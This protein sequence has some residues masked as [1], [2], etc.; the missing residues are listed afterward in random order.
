MRDHSIQT[1]PV[2]L[3][4]VW[5]S[6]NSQGYAL[7]DDREMGLSRRFPDEFRQMHFNKYILRH[8]QGDRPADRLRARDVVRYWRHDGGLSLQEHETIT[9]TDRADIPGKRDHS[10]VRLLS[11]P[12]ARK[13][14]C[15]FLQLV[16]P[17]RR[18]P[19]GTFGLNLFRT[20]TN[21]VTQPHHDQEEFIIVYVL[22]RIGG[23]AETYLYEPDGVAET[24]DPIA[25]PV[26]R[27]QL[28]KGEILIFED[29]L[30]KHGATPLRNPSGGTAMRDA[31]VCTVDHRGTYLAESAATSSAALPRTKAG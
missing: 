19:E 13:L 30:F 6:L 27:H 31:L 22:T 18:K 12:Q 8:D 5:A 2:D 14:I 28:D 9:I 25:E 11:D 23:G 4:D 10:R 26:L 21:I 7:T 16:P 1:G 3:K 17:S 24:G 15:T 20:F 29:K